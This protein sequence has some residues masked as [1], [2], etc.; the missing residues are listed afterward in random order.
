[1]SFVMSKYTDVK[2]QVNKS[3]GKQVKLPTLCV[4]TL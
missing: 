2:T 1:M 4:T 3:K